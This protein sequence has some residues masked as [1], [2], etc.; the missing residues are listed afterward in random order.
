MH[1]LAFDRDWTV[2]VNP[3]PGREA[4]PLEWIRYW[5]SKT[6]HKV[7]AIGN[8][9]LVEEADIP[10]VAEAVRR[11]DG[12]LDR[13]GEQDDRGRY[14]FWPEREDRLHLL[15]ELCPDA[16]RYIVVDDLDLSHV[17]GWEHYHAWDFLP[18]VRNGTLSLATPCHHA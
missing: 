4:V 10:G 7:W 13:L 5:A 8:Q 11:H 6:E 2:D 14:E 16:E 9:R 12:N 18:L 17:D 3:Y 1:V 15:A